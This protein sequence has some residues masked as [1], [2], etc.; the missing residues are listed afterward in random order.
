MK[1][2]VLFGIL[3]FLALIV[4]FAFRLIENY[5]LY[6]FDLFVGACC[7]L[8]SLEFSKLLVKRDILVSQ[9]ASGLY[10]SL[11]F[12]I[13]MFFFMFSSDILLYLIL[14]L[15]GLLFA[16]I[17]TFIIYLCLNTK[18]ILL[19]LKENKISK[20]KYAIIISL[21]TF[22]TFIYP[23]FLLLSLMILNRIDLFNFSKLTSSNGYL[24]WISLVI[25]FV[26]P[27]ISDTFA[28]L[29]G[30]FLKGKK[31][32]EKISPK[33]TVSGSVTALVLT[34]ATMGALYFCLISIPALENLI[35]ILNFK[36][37]NFMLLGFLGSAISQA[38][39]LF[40]SYLKRKANVK[41]SGNIF[42]GHGGFL[43]R[44]DSHIFN[45][46]FVLLFIIL[47]III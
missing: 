22:L 32:C 9:M 2:K 43:D 35:S 20:F 27:I 41:D 36:L 45:A 40:E 26:I 24:S 23:S 15:S 44:L 11:M 16:F 37:W 14:Q 30:M 33:K 8:C 25:A 34:S 13:H 10:P 4:A 7:I 31:L 19:Y 6:V 1:K 38:G 42:P 47:T 21:K 28:M 18:E 39:D 3:M 12:A 46:P 5:G 17:L 29:G